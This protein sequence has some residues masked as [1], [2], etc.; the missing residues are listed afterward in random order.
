MSSSG[1]GQRAYCRVKAM[2]GPCSC[3]GRTGNAMLLLMRERCWLDFGRKQPAHLTIHPSSPRPQHQIGNVSVDWR[4]SHDSFVYILPGLLITP[5]IPAG[6]TFIDHEQHSRCISFST[7]PRSFSIT[8]VVDHPAPYVYV[9]R[10][11]NRSLRPAILPRMY[12]PAS[13]GHTLAPSLV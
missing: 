10:V 7:T 2:R 1:R 3:P 5:Q 8:T 12:P 11:T 13:L 9:S 4:A 6:F